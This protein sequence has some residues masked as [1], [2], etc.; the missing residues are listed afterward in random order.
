MLFEREEHI[1]GMVWLHGKCGN[2]D[3][4]VKVRWK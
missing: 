4:N 2:C 3:S 1:Q